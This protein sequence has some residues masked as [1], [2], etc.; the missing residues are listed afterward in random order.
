MG[1][2][3]HQS[4][5]L[6]LTHTE[7]TKFYGGKKDGHAD[8]KNAEFRRLPFSCCSLSLQPFEHP[9]ISPDG[10]I[11]DITSIVPFLKQFGIN[12][13][14]GE[15]LVSK[16]LTK[17]QFHKN[18]EDRYHC[19]VTF[20]I[21]NENTHIVAVKI[22][23]NVFSYE[24]VERLNIKPGNWK[25]LI[26]GEDFVRKD[27]ITIQDPL[28]LKKF[29]L[30]KFFHLKKNLKVISEE[31]ESR[32]NSR[33]HLKAVNS[34][35]KSTLDELDRD[36][37]LPEKLVEKVVKA[38]AINAAHYSTGKVAASFTSTAVEPETKHEAAIIKEDT[39]RYE[40]IKKKAYVRILTNYGLINLEL[41]SDMIPKACEN[42][43]KHCQN[44]YYND[45]IFHRS[46]RN[47]M[48]QGGDPDGTGTGG[49]S[50]WEKPF[51]DEFK[52][53]LTHS[54]RGVLSMANSGPN[55]NK[56]QFFITFRSCRHLDGKHTVFGRVV[57]GLE[58]L[59]KMEKIKTDDKDKPKSEIKF[60]AAQVFQDPYEEV[61]EM[62][63]NE[64]EEAIAKE[65]AA[66][67]AS[68]Q[69]KKI[70][71]RDAK[72]KTY[73]SGIGKYINIKSLGKRSI[74]DDSEVN[75]EETVKLKKHAKS[76][77]NDFS[78]W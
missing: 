22:S 8:H 37:K 63:K 18:S 58:T 40:R 25:D 61:D 68:K 36:F 62:L 46:I 60:L 54:G 11:F 35:T 34:E 23:G 41:Y 71:I 65:K 76:N 16:D 3:Q 69:Q 15:K 21:F 4:D 45:T 77:L 51:K 47:F 43:L 75:S 31:E 48:I 19:P 32:K 38:D 24:A 64:R 10:Y 78:S 44:G 2:K 56:S 73:K 55:T 50:I 30:S 29:N 70:A 53:N 26:S 59:D 6:Y 57:G 52:P 12:P 28:D 72:P 74:D 33:Y 17:L 67:L 7:W 20:K 14:T 1:K 27:L 5:K 49:N 42:F 66:V 13:V 9:Y 39:L